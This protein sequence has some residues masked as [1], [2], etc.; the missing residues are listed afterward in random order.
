MFIFYHSKNLIKHQ[1]CRVKIGP[2]SEVFFP[3]NQETFR[4]VQRKF[5]TRGEANSLETFPHNFWRGPPFEQLLIYIYFLAKNLNMRSNLGGPSVPRPH[6][7][8][9]HAGPISPPLLYWI[10]G[11][12][13][14]H[15]TKYERELDIEKI[16][17]A[18]ISISK[19]LFYRN[20]C[21]TTIDT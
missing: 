17:W 6:Q 13:M 16:A 7:V 20:E 5:Y 11:R 10:G 2:Y 1:N 4:A 19:Y 14:N 12:S 9:C 15:I 18:E 3:L 8:A 21:L